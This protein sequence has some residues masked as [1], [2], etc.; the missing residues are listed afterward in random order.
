MAAMDE[1]MRGACWE[2]GVYLRGAAVL[3]LRSHVS[4]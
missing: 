2:Q 1:A 4:V 3:Q